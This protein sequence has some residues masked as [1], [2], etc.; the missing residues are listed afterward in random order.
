MSIPLP[1]KNCKV[2]VL[3]VFFAIFALG[4]L[5]VFKM[6][7][8][9]ITDSIISTKQDVTSDR[10][11]SYDPAHPCGVVSATIVTY[12]LSRPVDF[13]S[14]QKLIP[15][16]GMGRVSMA[17]L[18]KSLRKVGFYAVGVR[19]DER[20]LQNEQG[21]PVILYVNQSHFLVVIPTGDGNMVVIDPPHEPYLLTVA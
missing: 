2:V 19:L 13:S 21:S 16:D 11:A 6:A 8:M 15:V 17:D 20:S 10:I 9:R 7:Y 18:I 14:M 5:I 4:L 3:L 12:L 1:L